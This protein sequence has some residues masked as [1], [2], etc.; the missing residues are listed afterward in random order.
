ML[1]RWF[2]MAVVFVALAAC[3]DD[4]GEGMDS[5]VPDSG[6]GDSGPGDSGDTSV[7]DTSVA[8]TSV[9]DSGTEA[10]TS[11]ADTSVGDAGDAGAGFPLDHPFPATSTGATITR[12][13]ND[14]FVIAYTDDVDTSTGEGEELVLQRVVRDGHSLLFEA[15]QRFTQTSIAPTSDNPLRLMGSLGEAHFFIIVGLPGYAHVTRYFKVVS[16]SF[17]DIGS[18]TY[19]GTDF[20][21]PP[22]FFHGHPVD[23]TRHLLGYRETNSGE[24]VQYRL[25]IRDADSFSLGAPVARPPP[26]AFTGLSTSESQADPALVRMGPTTFIE[27]RPGYVFAPGTMATWTLEVAAGNTLAVSAPRVHTT[28]EQ[29]MSPEVAADSHGGA[30]IAYA[31]YAETDWSYGIYDHGTGALTETAVFAVSSDD[32]SI[33][34]HQGESADRFL[35]G[36][37]YVRLPGTSGASS[38]DAP[39][40]RIDAGDGTV[41]RLV[42]V[43]NLLACYRAPQMVR[44]GTIAAY[45][46]CDRVKFVD[47]LPLC[48]DGALDDGEA[49]DDGNNDDGDTCT[50]GCTIAP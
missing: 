31:T 36:S 20:G 50:A 44:T 1:S 3:G 22:A 43:P 26:S 28:L 37:Y 30:L 35:G 46:G 23:A 9:G 10:D 34:A 39:L 11:V 7:A 21:G 6:A 5:S 19:G 48:G 49:C 8:D 33:R 40:F 47:L 16:G 25:I 2:A 17:V 18:A 15:P 41:S 45:L 27:A 32:A 14:A 24:P 42:D 12:L 4:A 38:A 29:T 13:G